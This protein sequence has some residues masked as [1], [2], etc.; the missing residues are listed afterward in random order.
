[1][2]GLAVVA[3]SVRRQDQR[4]AAAICRQEEPLWRHMITV[5]V[6]TNCE[7]ESTE[8]AELE[9]LEWPEVT[10]RMQEPGHAYPVAAFEASHDRMIRSSNSRASGNS[11]RSCAKGGSRF[12]APCRARSP[13]TSGWFAD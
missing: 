3:R 10:L 9:S 11:I 12:V 2:V 4:G 13:A 1:M 7:T 6:V 8:V 5:D